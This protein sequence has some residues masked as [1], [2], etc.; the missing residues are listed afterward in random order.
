MLIGAQ[1]PTI[2]LCFDDDMDR[3]MSAWP[4]DWLVGHQCAAG[5]KGMHPREQRRFV[6]KRASSPRPEFFESRLYDTLLVFPRD[7]TLIV[8]R[9]TLAGSG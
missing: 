6:R 3:G 5:A 8:P 4:L 7:S 2:L 1:C 9:R